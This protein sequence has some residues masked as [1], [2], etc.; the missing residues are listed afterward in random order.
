MLER[1]RRE[2][3]FLVGGAASFL[4]ALFFWGLMWLWTIS[5]ELIIWLTLPLSTKVAAMWSMALFVCLLGL[6]IFK[7]LISVLNAQKHYRS[8]AAQRE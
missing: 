1:Q 5:R 7:S 4:A 3:F 6:R 2:C 8:V